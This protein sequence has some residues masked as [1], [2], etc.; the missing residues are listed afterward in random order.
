M[1][2]NQE[3][4]QL[5]DRAAATTHLRLDLDSLFEGTFIYSDLDISRRGHEQVI[6]VEDKEKFLDEMAAKFRRIV[7]RSLTPINY[8]ED[9][10]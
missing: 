7:E 9:E 4:K 10:R 8:N 5:A 6:K 1:Q 2:T 3:V